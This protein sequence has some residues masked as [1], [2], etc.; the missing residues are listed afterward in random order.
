[1]PPTRLT[2]AVPL[3]IGRKTTSARKVVGTLRVP[4]F[5]HAEREEYFADAQVI[6]RWILVLWLLASTS[7]RPAQAAKVTVEVANVP[8]VKL[9]GAVNRFDQDGNLRRLPDEKAKVDEP[10]LDATAASNGTSQWVFKDLPP[11]KYDLVI[12]AEGRL[13]I[14]GFQFAPVKEFDPFISPDAAPDD[15]TREFISDDIQKSRHFENQVVP[16]YLAGDKNKKAV[17]VLV[18][19]IRDQPTS[20]KPGLGTIRHEIWQYTWHY[21]GWEKEKRTKVLDRILLPVA[22]LHQWTWLWDPKLGGIEVRNAPLAIHYELP[23]KSG[24]QKIKGLY[25][26][27][28]E[29]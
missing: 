27:R 1:M 20:Y 6:C 13:R 21:G 22:E 23:N 4:R 9:V 15:E 24:P 11:G 14:E 25:P 10:Y 3:R 12:L 8:G 29:R 18:M 5:P 28:D 19:L 7:L 2:A 16:L 17:R 26:S